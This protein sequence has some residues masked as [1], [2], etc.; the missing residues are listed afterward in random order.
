MLVCVGAQR[1]TFLVRFSAA[2]QLAFAVCLSACLPVCLIFLS[3]CACN[4]VLRRNCT[5]LRVSGDLQTPQQFVRRPP[6]MSQE[7]QVGTR[8][9]RRATTT[10]RTKCVFL[11]AE[12]VL[13]SMYPDMPQ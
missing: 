10:S 2:F 4:R 5:L 7:N 13:Q 6:D 12:N 8:Q 3:V 11:P 1:E 9:G